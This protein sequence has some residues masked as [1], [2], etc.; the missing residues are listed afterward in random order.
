M[1]MIVAHLKANSEK[2]EKLEECV[3]KEKLDALKR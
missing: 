2:L 1:E 3:F